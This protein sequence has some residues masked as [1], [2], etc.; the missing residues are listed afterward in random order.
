MIKPGKQALNHA[1]LRRHLCSIRMPLEYKKITTRI[2]LTS[3]FSWVYVCGGLGGGHSPSV[4][5]IH[6]GGGGILV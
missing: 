4:L 6:G 2:L 3:C 5:Y 1:T